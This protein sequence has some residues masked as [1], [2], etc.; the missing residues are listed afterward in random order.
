MAVRFDAATD[1]YVGAGLSGSVATVICWLYISVDRNASSTAWSMA[2]AS[3]EQA[4]LQTRVDGVTIGLWDAAFGAEIVG[5]AM[6]VD[7]WYAVAAVMN[8]TAWSLYTG[9]DPGSLTLASA[10]RTALSSPTSLRIGNE[11]TDTEFW[12]GRVANFKR[13]TAALSESEIRTELLQYQPIRTANIVDYFHFVNAG[14]VDYSG[15]GNTLTAGSTATAT[16]AGPPIRW[17]GRLVRQT[18]VP[19]AGTASPAAQVASFTFAAQDP[20]VTRTG[21]ANA[22]SVSFGVAG[23]NANASVFASAQ[24]ASVAFSVPTAGATDES[25]LCAEFTTSV[26]ISDRHS[27]AVTVGDRHEAG[28]TPDAHVGDV[29]VDEHYAT[30]GICGRS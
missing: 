26:T 22:E 19:T 4:V 3:A 14:T 27:G 7:T 20:T 30:V 12:N 18:H 13:Y 6:S 9:T 8:G 25:I 29:A 15:N 17:D 2:G 21:N 16:E 11:R 10:T 28:V 23:Q 24:V 1:R 5:P